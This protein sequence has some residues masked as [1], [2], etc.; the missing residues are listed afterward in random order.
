MHLILGVLTIGIHPAS[1]V[2]MRVPGV[3]QGRL[4]GLDRRMDGLAGS[5]YGGIQQ[6]HELQSRTIA[7]AGA[8]PDMT[9]R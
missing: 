2:F 3:L 8:S 1:L 5:G 4:L 7:S 9:R 6:R